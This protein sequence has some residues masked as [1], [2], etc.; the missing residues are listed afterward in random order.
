[1]LFS[2]T[3]SVMAGGIALLA[4]FFAGLWFQNRTVVL[5][6][7]TQTSQNLKTRVAEGQAYSAV[8]IE[9]AK[10]L[11]A[12]RVDSKKITSKF[13]GQDYESPMLVRAIVAAASQSGMEMT[14]TS[15]QDKKTN[16]IATKGKGLTVQE[17]SY[18]ITLKGTYMAL[19]K[20]LQNLAAWN[21]GHKINSV[22]VTPAV[23]GKATDEIKIS[24]VLSVFALE[25]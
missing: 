23:E 17:L 15:Q 6:E 8:V 11:G 5:K 13:V 9:Y 4:V 24:C 3:K 7:L 10:R 22:E 16:I 14:D 18:A 1:M 19:V 12:L 21:T 20:F 25:Q 2:H